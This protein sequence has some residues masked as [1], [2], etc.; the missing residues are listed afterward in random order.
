[1]FSSGSS[2]VKE[3]SEKKYNGKMEWTRGL[4]NMLAKE[5]RV[6]WGTRKWIVQ[7]ILWTLV[8]TGSVAFTL[9]VLSILPVLRRPDVV[10]GY[11]TGAAALQL[12][13]NI[14]GFTFAIGVIVIT[15]D[16]IVGERE[17]GTAE[18]VLS[19]PLSRK[20]FVLSKIVA[21]TIGISATMVILQGAFLLLVARLFHGDID[22]FPFA[23]GLAV[24]WLVC[25]FYITFVVF[26]GTV[27][28]S[29]GAVLGVAFLFFLTG[30][31]LPLA[32]EKTFYFMPWRLSDVGFAFSMSLAGNAKLLLPILMTSIWSLLFTAGALWRIEKIEI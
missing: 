6:W 5:N 24:M 15:H 28:N 21:S 19:K 9:Y 22:F 30:F 17:T 25:F 20:A 7:S 11:G 29:R 27:L 23:K 14:S 26:L 32:F 18:W 13:F 31:L 1:M 16:I 12:F 3:M 8:I 4:M 10:D 2:G